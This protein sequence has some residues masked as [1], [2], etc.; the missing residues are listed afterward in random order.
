[1][2]FNYSINHHLENHVKWKAC[3]LKSKDHILIYLAALRL[4]ALEKMAFVKDNDLHL[5]VDQLG[6]LFRQEIVVDDDH[7]NVAQKI[8]AW[9]ETIQYYFF[10]YMYLF[11]LLP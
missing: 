5:F 1:M 2:V 6:L 7:T 8:L 3:S 11:Y 4:A 10:K 9:K